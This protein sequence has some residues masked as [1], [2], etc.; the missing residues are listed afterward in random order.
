MLMLASDRLMMG[1]CRNRPFV[2]PTV[3]ATDAAKAIDF[4]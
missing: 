3:C 2:N 1:E 4:D